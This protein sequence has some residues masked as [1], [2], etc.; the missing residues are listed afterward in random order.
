MKDTGM[1]IPVP[2]MRIRTRKAV[3]FSPVIPGLSA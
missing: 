3:A 1:E 2:K